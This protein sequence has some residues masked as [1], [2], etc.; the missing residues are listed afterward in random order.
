MAGYL[1]S[2]FFALSYG[3]THRH[4]LLSHA[5]PQVQDSI[6]L[7]GLFLLIAGLSIRWVAILSLGRSFSVNVA[8]HSTQTVYRRG[9]YSRLRHPSYTGMLVI[10][11]AIGTETR[12]W[13]SLA[14]MLIFPTLALL[15]RIHV[16]EAALLNAF[17]T[18]YTDYS[19]S[20][21]RLIPGIY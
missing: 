16:E 3:A 5:S 18:E 4:T 14:V 19:R 9:L 17:G 7:L 21:K 2:I 8:I 13:L 20:T 10:F 12:N 6:R 1:L 15:Y 11:L